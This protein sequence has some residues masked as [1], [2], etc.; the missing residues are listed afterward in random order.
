MK[1][2]HWFHLLLRRVYFSRIYWISDKFIHTC[3]KC[4]VTIFSPYLLIYLPHSRRLLPPPSPILLSRLII[5]CCS[6]IGWHSCYTYDHIGCIISRWQCF[7]PLV[8]TIQL[9]IFALSFSLVFPVPWSGW[10]Q[11]S[12]LVPS[13]WQSFILSTW[14]SYAFLY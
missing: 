7:V 6:C 4:S 5:W 13:N 14:N 3:T 2:W 8:L 11:Y 1:S 9:L 12:I 10:Y